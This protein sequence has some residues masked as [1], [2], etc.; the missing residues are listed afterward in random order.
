M[1]WSQAS[2]LHFNTLSDVVFLLELLMVTPR[3]SVLSRIAIGLISLGLVAWLAISS[4]PIESR[5]RAIND[6]LRSGTIG[7]LSSSENAEFEKTLAWLVDASGFEAGRIQVN[8]PYS[9]TTKREGTLQVFVTSG[10]D[11]SFTHCGFGNA[12]YDSELD[13]VFIDRG[14][15][16]SDEWN[17]LLSN[18]DGS[19]VSLGLENAPWLRTYL[20]FIVLHEL[21]HRKL[22]RHLSRSFDLTQSKRASALRKIEEQADQLAYINL[23]NG[24]RTAKRF[25]IDPDEKDSGDLINF[26]VSPQTTLA[27]RIQISIT[28][29]AFMVSA[30]G[31]VLSEKN[32]L[33]GDFAH[34]S[35]VNRA[36]EFLHASLRERDI[37]PRLRTFTEYVQ[38]GLQRMEAVVANGM[39]GVTSSDLIEGVSFDDQGLVIVRGNRLERIP[40]GRV[41]SLIHEHRFVEIQAL[42][43]WAL[44]FDRPTSGKGREI[45]DAMWSTAGGGSFVCFHSG[46]GAA[47][48]A[49]FSAVR[50]VSSEESHCASISHTLSSSMPSGYSVTYGFGDPPVFTAWKTEA[51]IASLS[52]TDVQ[53]WL[54]TQ[55]LRGHV[56]SEGTLAQTLDDVLFVPVFDPLQGNRLVGYVRVDVSTMRPIAFESLQTSLTLDNAI[57]H[58]ELS[59]GRLLFF[60]VRGTLAIRLVVLTHAPSNDSRLTRLQFWEMSKENVPVLLSEHKLQNI[61]LSKEDTQNPYQSTRI[62]RDATRAIGDAVLVNVD[63][64]SMYLLNGRESRFIFHPGSVTM[65]LAAS[66]NGIGAVYEHPGYRLFLFDE[67][68]TAPPQNAASGNKVF[69]VF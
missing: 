45:V 21:A 66:R 59:D 12:I 25:G 32:P 53:G 10:E 9:D 44:T 3:S 60:N 46:E 49:A 19:D 39:A 40:Y 65:R 34:P 1:V 8:K 67:I 4:R 56:S 13:A 20:R 2:V 36:D 62:W 23:R 58:N 7:R 55:G 68:S 6:G 33:R 48:D 27:D 38:A 26:K 57:G 42:A 52:A 47:V 63:D 15:V 14:I 30:G 31:L 50:L 22:H 11:E 17:M 29:M 28:E 18:P 24:Y 54:A 51:R 69:G 16:S 5:V 41:K 35:F 37:E 43:T 61:L 64:D